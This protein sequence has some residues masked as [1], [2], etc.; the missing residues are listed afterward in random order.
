MDLLGFARTSPAAFAKGLLDA[1]RAEVPGLFATLLEAL[2][3]DRERAIS[4]LLE[5]DDHA[6]FVLMHHAG[7][8]PK[9]VTV[10]QLDRC[11]GGPEE[12]GWWYDTGFVHDTRELRADE[13][14]EALTKELETEYGIPSSYRS[15]VRPRGTDYD[16]RFSLFPG[17]NW[18]A[19][20]PHYE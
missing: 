17:A 14:V 2:D 5:I 11:F 20:R 3:G 4:T 7:V 6:E 1:D 19:V 10:Y 18:P 12:G 16:V 9:F 8:R 15:S 13:D